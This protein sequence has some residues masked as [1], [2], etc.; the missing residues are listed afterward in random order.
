MR[1]AAVNS[2]FPRVESSSCAAVR[3]LDLQ[4][5]AGRET[6]KNNEL[7]RLRG[8][9]RHRAAVIPGAAKA[10]SLDS[11]IAGGGYWIL[12]RAPMPRRTDQLHTHICEN[13]ESI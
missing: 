10:A 8:L 6:M 12:R 4:E 9:S 5:I 1:T 3:K 7:P 2:L 11:V 13:T